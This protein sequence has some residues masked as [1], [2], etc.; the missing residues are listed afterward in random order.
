MAAVESSD[1]EMD[2]GLSDKGMKYPDDYIGKVIEGDCL[3]VMREMPDKC[4]DLCLTDFPYGVGID[5]GAFDDSQPHLEELVSSAMP[6]ILRISKVALITCGVN[7][8]HL[9]PKTK[10]TLC[11][12]FP[13]NPGQSPWGFPCWQPILAYG[14]CPDLFTKGRQSDV[15]ISTEHSEK[16]TGHPCP[17]PLTLWKK[18]L[19]R[20]SIK[21]S[22]KVFDPFMGSGTTALAAMELERQWCGSEL[23]PKYCDIARK[24]IAAEQAQ[25]KLF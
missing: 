19:L 17:K 12:Y 22:D 15:I 23:S 9:Y 24:R 18:I 1:T 25:G 4:I 2:S 6:E 5:Y 8:I 11:I 14:S 16:N 21:K 13:A 10:W 20:G 3:S 7:N